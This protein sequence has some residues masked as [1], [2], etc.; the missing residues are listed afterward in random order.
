[1]E[2]DKCS[3]LSLPMQVVPIY[4]GYKISMKILVP[5]LSTR[6]QFIFGSGSH[7]FM[8]SVSDGRLRAQMFLGA[9]YDNTGSGLVHAYSK[10]KLVPGKWNDV[11]IVYD[12]KTFTVYLNG[13]SGEP[14][15]VTGSQM[16]PKAGILGGGEKRDNFFTGKIKDL[17]IETL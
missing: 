16:R 8:L 11:S 17:S 12:Q 7:G 4:A 10:G 2:F 9:R 6:E 5:E 3:Y 15:E 1:M 14:V 13:E